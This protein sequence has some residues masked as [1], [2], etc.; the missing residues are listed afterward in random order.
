MMRKLVKRIAVVFAVCLLLSTVSAGY[1]LTIATEGGAA[2]LGEYLKMHPEIEVVPID[3]DSELIQKALD[4]SADIDLYALFTL[5]ST[6]FENLRDKGYFLTIEDAEIAAWT[7]SVYPEILEAVTYDGAI[8][9]VPYVLVLQEE[10]GVD[11]DVWA[12]LGLREEDLPRTWGQLMRFALEEWPEYADRYP[13]VQLFDRMDYYR[14]LQNIDN[15]YEAYRAKNNYEFGYD[16]PEYREIL[17]LFHQLS[18]RDGENLQ[19]AASYYLFSS[20]YV[21]T[22]RTGYGNIRSLRLSFKEG[23]EAYCGVGMF[24]I[25][26]NPNTQNLEEA[27]EL[28]QYLIENNSILDT[29][30]L[31]PTENAPVIGEIYNELMGEYEAQMEVY[32]QRLESAKTEAD[33]KEIEM[34]RD[35][36]D[37]QMQ[38]FIEENKYDASS[39]SIQQYREEVEHRMVPIYRTGLSYEE[40]DVV[41]EKRQLF[42]EGQISADQYITE[43]ERRFVLNVLENQ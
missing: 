27:I 19:N 31:I 29:M 12:E 5:K 10:M 6:V 1:A 17:E 8:C 22:V 7:Q 14:I 40:Y 34:E 21:P 43:L 32:A 36:Y 18:A 15:N 37:Q 13:D 42:L 4:R 30:E 11:L 3:D 23:D 35:A 25:A 28:M 24:V 38:Q 33:A 41:N 2:T 9:A 20:A 26:I 16:T 39:E